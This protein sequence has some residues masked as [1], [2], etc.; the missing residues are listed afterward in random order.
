MRRRLLRLLPRLLPGLLSRLGVGVVDVAPG[1]VAL[2]RGVRLRTLPLPDGSTVVAT[3]KGVR[4]LPLPDGSTVVATGK[5]VRALPLPGGALVTRERGLRTLTLRDGST[6][7][8]RSR[9]LRSVPLPGA[10]EQDPDSLLLSDR[11]AKV[12]QVSPAQVLVGGPRAPGWLSRGHENA[13]YD[14]LASEHVVTVLHH[15]RGNCVLDVGANKGQ[16]ARRLRAAGYTGWIVS[17]EPVAA[18]FQVLSERAARDPR[19]TVHQVALG[20]ESGETEMNV[21]PGT[22]SSLLPPTTYGAERYTRLQG[23]ATQRVQVRR[24]DELWDEVTGHV[25]DCRPYLKLDT[26]GFDLEVF[27]G[28]GRRAEQLVGMQSEVALLKIYEA[29]PTMTEAL[30][31]YGAAGFEVSAMFPVSRERRTGRV[32]EFD[33]LLVR[34]AALPPRG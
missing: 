32:L 3:G 1:A 5:G 33:C 22:L 30:D 9:T 8:T 28:L 15:Y 20:R 18:D 19:W 34:K 16:Y 31:V 25:P 13:L 29:M 23:A 24:L 7:I 21:V 17:F 12:V 6:V 26:Q 2:S 10:G 4:T 11:R 27:R 14:T